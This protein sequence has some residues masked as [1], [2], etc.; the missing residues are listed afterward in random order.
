M[1]HMLSL[2]PEYSPKYAE[3]LNTVNGGMDSAAALEKVYGK[4]VPAVEKDLNAY[5]RGNQ[6]FGRLFP[7]KLASAREKFPATPAPSFDLKLALTDLT[8]RP[9]KE[10]ETRKA[11]E[12]LTREDPKRPEPWAGLGYLAWRDNQIAKLWKRSE[13]LTGWAII[14]LNF[15][16]TLDAWPSA[17]VPKK[18]S[19]R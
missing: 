12:D 19:T 10:A 16:G 7:V 18:R 3:F 11:L 4:T 14:A 2:S 5:F 17:S 1:V 15:S 13:R 8:N 6:F 9:G